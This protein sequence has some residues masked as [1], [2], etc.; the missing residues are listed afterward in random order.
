[1]ILISDAVVSAG[2]GPGKYSYYGRPVISGDRGVRYAE[3]EVLIGSTCLIPEVL[4]RFVAVTGCTIEAAIEA[5]TLNPLSLL[6]R[7]GE[8]GSISIG[9]RADIVLFDDTLTVKRN[10]WA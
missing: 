10:L 5:A 8:G 3:N 4:R 2:L 9:K 7:S 1:M 6:G